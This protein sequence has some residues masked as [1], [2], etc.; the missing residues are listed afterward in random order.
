MH[1]IICDNLANYMKLSLTY[2]T[3]KRKLES[4]L[5][6]LLKKVK[7]FNYQYMKLCQ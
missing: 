6:I 5:K 2:N 1:H 7:V 3:H 4:I